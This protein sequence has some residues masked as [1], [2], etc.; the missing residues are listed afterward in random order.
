MRSAGLVVAVSGLVFILGT[1]TACAESETFALIVTNNRSAS[2]DRP[3][4][5]YA[6][7]DGARY[8]A[9]FRSVASDEN[10]LLLTRFDRGSQQTYAE[11]AAMVR[12]PQ[13]AELQTAV[14]KLRQHIERAQKA[15][16]QTTFYFV[17][18][19][20]GDVDHGKGFLE[21]E[22]GKLDADFLEHQ[23]IE[24]IPADVQHIVL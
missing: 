20:H 5:Q 14:T 23:I 10:V 18:A 24:K 9:L 3:D 4:L 16:H 2:L 17:F 11:L 15:G 19:G 6:D 7:D 12:P 13:M 21:L 1:G 22:D 8:H